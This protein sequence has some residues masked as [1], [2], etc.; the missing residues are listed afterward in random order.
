MHL[1]AALDAA[2]DRYRVLGRGLV[3]RH[4]LEAPGE[5][6]ILLDVAA[7]LVGGGGADAAQL[8]ARQGRLQHVGGVH[9]PFRLAGADQRVQFVDED[10]DL[11]G[12]GL[13]LLQY[14]LQPFLELAAVF[15]AGDHRAE[16]ERQ[17]ALVL[18]ALRHVAIDDAQRQPLDDRGLADAGLP[19]QHRIVLGAPRQHLD[20]AAD[21]FVA[22][23]HRIELALARRF[24]QV[25][26]VF[27][28]GI[29]AFLGRGGVGLTA[30]A[31][32]FDC[33]VEALR[34]NPT[35]RQ[36]LSGGRV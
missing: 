32:L 10:D 1:V 9:R 25:A 11:A 12:R 6:R 20:R 22:A 16:I 31:H 2:Q 29:V 24:C 30:L 14:G 23:D 5:R 35:S 18:Q 13:D 15:G 7:V 4:R 28:Q 33:R 19:D 17:Q 36:S 8:A 26:R 34:G 27:L 21:L 3:D